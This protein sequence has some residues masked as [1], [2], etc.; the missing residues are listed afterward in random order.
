[1]TDNERV[2]SDCFEAA[3]YIHEQDRKPNCAISHEALQRVF[4]EA[5]DAKD[6]QAE[7]LRHRLADVQETLEAEQNSTLRLC[8]ELRDKKSELLTANLHIKRLTEALRPYAEE[9]L[10]EEAKL[11]EEIFKMQQKAKEALSLSPDL[12][13]VE[14]LLN[15]VKAVKYWNTAP[16]DG[17]GRLVDALAALER[18]KG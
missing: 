3:E 5:L 18:G 12:S 10:N 4:K 7:K 9:E 1:M 15:L 11:L 2:V 6:S 17:I 16:P 14:G 13:E 8:A